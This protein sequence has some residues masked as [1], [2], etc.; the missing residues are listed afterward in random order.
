MTDARG[1]TVAD[2]VDVATA[3]GPLRGTIVRRTPVD[4]GDGVRSAVRLHAP[5]R[6]TLCAVDDASMSFAERPVNPSL[7]AL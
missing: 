4:C 6:G 3:V 7:T 1:F 2:V 5:H